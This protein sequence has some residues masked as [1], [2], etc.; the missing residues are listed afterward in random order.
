[1]LIEFAARLHDQLGGGGR[2]GGSNIGDKIGDG[3]IGFVANAR[4]YGKF[5]CGDGAG[6]FFFIEGPQIF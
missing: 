4:D 3:E 6:D 5:G 2:S 1:V